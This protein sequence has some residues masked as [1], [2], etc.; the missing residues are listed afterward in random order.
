[1]QAKCWKMPFC[2]DSDRARGKNPKPHFNVG[3]RPLAT[4]AASPTQAPLPRNVPPTKQRRRLGN[5][6]KKI[7]KIHAI[8]ADAPPPARSPD[9]Q[10]QRLL[11]RYPSNIRR[12]IESI[13][14]QE[15][16]VKRES[17]SERACDLEPMIFVSVRVLQITHFITIGVPC[18]CP[19]VGASPALKR[20]KLEF[21]TPLPASPSLAA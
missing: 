18:T 12:A 4:A 5:L 13:A 8:N 16:Q 17:P 10:Q 2:E 21:L 11:F 7:K 6:Q 3:K 1:M 19:H 14:G 15:K 20:G 9:A